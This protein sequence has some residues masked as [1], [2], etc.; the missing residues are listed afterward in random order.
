VP[1]TK[2]PPLA[3]ILLSVHN[4]ILV[5]YG[6]YN[7]QKVYHHVNMKLHTLT[8]SI[9]ALILLTVALTIA[10]AA[11]FAYGQWSNP[12]V[13]P[14]GGNIAVPVN[15][16]S[17]D[18]VKTGSLSVNNLTARNRTT[19]IGS[20][21]Q[22]RFIDTTS[23]ARDFWW[24]VDSNVM[25]LLA[26]R[27]NDGFYADDQEYP[28]RAYAGSNSNSD[29]F[30]VSNEVRANEYCDRNGNN[31]ST[32]RQIRD[33]VRDTPE[34]DC[35]RRSNSARG[36]TDRMR[37]T[38]SCRSDEVVTGGGCAAYYGN[39][40]WMVQSFPNTASSW[41]CYKH[42]GDDPGPRFDAYALCCKLD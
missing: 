41:Q 3:G 29:Y 40:T 9:K 31:C 26:D 30:Q 23:G 32:P 13:S 6:C 17:T 37:L 24:H 2:S 16:S 5:R 20:S 27:D 42:V 33:A 1:I 36:T 19:I 22:V 11:N 28:V 39:L 38:A 25:Y 7:R 34:L 15:I 8:S 14:T 10:L 4:F 35:T 21:A 12:S 18:Q